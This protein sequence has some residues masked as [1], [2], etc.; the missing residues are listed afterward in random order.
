[1]LGGRCSL[2]AN[3]SCQYSY[4]YEWECC[5]TL[6]LYLAGDVSKSIMDSTLYRMNSLYI[7]DLAEW[8]ESLTANALVATV[9][10]TIP[11]SSD[12]DT[13]KSEGRQ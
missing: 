2:P 11:V 8:L 12:S 7:H 3:K 5:S 6:Y 9:L 13:V 10:G 1:M 4:K